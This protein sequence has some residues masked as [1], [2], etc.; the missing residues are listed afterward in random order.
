MAE[1]REQDPRD[2]VDSDEEYVQADPRD[3]VEE[4]GVAMSGPGGAPQEDESVEERRARDRDVAR[5]R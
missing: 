2:G 3:I 4:G 1:E 5:R